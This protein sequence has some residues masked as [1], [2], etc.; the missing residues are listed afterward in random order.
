[1]YS[2]AKLYYI[3]SRSLYS[4]IASASRSPYIYISLFT[5]PSH[6]K[7]IYLTLLFLVVKPLASY[8]AKYSSN[9]LN[10]HSVKNNPV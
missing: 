4:A 8:F 6:I 9:H 5:N 10:T 3:S 7:N 1:M 2:I